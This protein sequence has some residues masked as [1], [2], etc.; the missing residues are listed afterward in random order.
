MKCVTELLM[1]QRSEVNYVHYLWVWIAQP[2]KTDRETDPEGWL[3]LQMNPMVEQPTQKHGASNTPLEWDKTLIMVLLCSVGW[4]AFTFHLVEQN[5]YSGNIHLL[6]L[7][8]SLSECRTDLTQ[9][10]SWIQL[11]CE[12]LLLYS[13]IGNARKITLFSTYSPHWLGVNKMMLNDKVNHQDLEWMDKV[14][15]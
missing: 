7:R 15:K 4:W 12:S 3:T 10:S 1:P 6:L 14:W 2:S 13:S 9:C 5:K 8:V 11:T